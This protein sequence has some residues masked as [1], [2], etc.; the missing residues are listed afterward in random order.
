MSVPAV[1]SGLMSRNVG[2]GSVECQWSPSAGASSYN[3]YLG[4]ASG[5]PFAKVNL[6]PI[7]ATTMRIPNIR[8]GLTVFVKVSAVNASGES[9]QSSLAL[10]A[11]C[12]PGT[13]TLRFEGLAGDTIP[14]GALFVAKVASGKL[15]SFVTQASGVCAVKQGVNPVVSSDGATVVSPD[16]AVVLS[17]T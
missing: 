8:L 4:T 14:A 16:G 10:D 5:G 9:A 12:S 3:V 15:V 17:A 6:A 13:T 11:T 2:N 1:P 7:R